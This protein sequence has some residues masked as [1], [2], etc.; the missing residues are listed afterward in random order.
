MIVVT[1]LS[2]YRRAQARIHRE[3]VSSHPSAEMGKQ[4][5][6]LRIILTDLATFCIDEFA[7][8]LNIKEQLSPEL[9]SRSLS[10]LSRSPFA[11]AVHTV[12]VR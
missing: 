10:R 3:V 12:S 7:T 5:C 11:H 2:G 4:L 6:A 1:R 9:K 8:A